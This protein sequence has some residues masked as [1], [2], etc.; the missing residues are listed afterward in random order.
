MFGFKTAESQTPSLFSRLKQG[1]SKT[2]SQFTKALANSLLGEKITDAQTLEEIE[3]Q[4]L[5]SDVG[6]KATEKIINTLI[7]EQARQNPSS[8]MTILNKALVDI[9]KPCAKPLVLSAQQPYVI[10][11]VGINGAGKTTTIGKLTKQLVREGKSVLL[12]A[13]DTFRAAAIEQLQVWGERNDIPVMAGPAGGDSAAIIFDALQ[14]AKARKIDVVIADTAGRLHTQQH[15]MDELGK[16]KRVIKK[17]DQ[18]A[19]HEVM[20]VLDAGIGQNALQQAKQFQHVVEVTGL[21]VTKLDGTAKG[22]IVFA[23]AEELG[24][25]IRYIGVGEAIDDLRPFEAEDFVAA[26]LSTD[27]G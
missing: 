5:M 11:M 13:G 3:T 6:V 15:L 1:L 7:Q 25:P 10:L 21:T 16:I 27:K 14:A 24:I 20:L 12:A 2:R 19:P 4:L 23:M 18:N 8:L 9:L 26:L 22:G 17:F